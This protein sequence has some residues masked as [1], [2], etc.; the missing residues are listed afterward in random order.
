MWANGECTLGYVPPAKKPEKRQADKEYDRDW[1]SHHEVLGDRRLKTR[2]IE[3]FHLDENGKSFEEVWNDRKNEL[4]PA[5]PPKG[6]NGITGY[7]A[8]MTRNGCHL[9]ERHYG[10]NRLVMVTPT[11]PENNPYFMLWTLDW[12]EIVR[13]FIQELQRELRR[14]N[15]PDHIIGVTEIHPKRSERL[16]FGVPHLHLVLV[17][18]DG[19][20]FEDGKRKYYISSD[21]FRELFQRVLRNSAIRLGVYQDDVPVPLPRV[22][23]ETIKKSAEGYLGKYLSK[24]KESLKKLADKGVTDINISHWW[25]CTKGLRQIIKR[26]IRE[27]R[28]DII[29]S[30][31]QNVDLVGRGVVYFLREVKRKMKSKPSRKDPLPETSE[32][33]EDRLFGYYFKL[34][35]QWSRIPKSELIQLFD[36]A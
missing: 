26:G 10:K 9:L 13:K 3:D 24:G 16:G 31:L 27:I 5:R 34:K 36:T 11:L 32:D 29:R 12:S 20:T 6:K 2:K 19:E 15:A 4:K 23:S 35:P 18:W 22:H 21:K 17:N 30:V 14:Q 28:E 25:H 7:G 8:R 1:L 33:G